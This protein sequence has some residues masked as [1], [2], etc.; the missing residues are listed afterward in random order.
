M[1]YKP[2]GLHLLAQISSRTDPCEPKI[3]T[4]FGTEVKLPASSSGEVLL[5][6]ADSG[7]ILSGDNTAI[8]CVHIGCPVGACSCYDVV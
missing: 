8:R 2:N 4:H 6:R 7:Q 1:D 3:F 5:R